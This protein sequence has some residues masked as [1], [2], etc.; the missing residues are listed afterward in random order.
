MFGIGL[1]VAIVTSV[2]ESK[3]TVVENIVEVVLRSKIGYLNLDTEM[4]Q[5]KQ[6]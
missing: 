3:S 1:A 6:E 2:V 5:Q 4:K